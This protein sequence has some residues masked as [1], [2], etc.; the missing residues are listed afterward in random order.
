M[1]KRALLLRKLI[2]LF[3][4]QYIESKNLDVGFKL[5]DLAWSRL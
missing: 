2:D 4:L 3:C 1:L 5:N